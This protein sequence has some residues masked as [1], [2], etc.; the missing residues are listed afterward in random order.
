MVLLEVVRLVS[1]LVQC[2]FINSFVKVKVSYCPVRTIQ[3][4]NLAMI[5][6]KTLRKS[7]GIIKIRDRN[8]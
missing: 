8:P 1:K 6:T 7:N 2:R 3:L 4:I 5:W